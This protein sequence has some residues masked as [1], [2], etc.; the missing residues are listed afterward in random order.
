MNAQI[1]PEIVVNSEAFAV[2]TQMYVRLRRVCGRVIDVMYLVHD[3]SYA[4][5]VAEIALAS[6]DVELQR[7]VAR[8]SNCLDLY[9]EPPMLEVEEIQITALEK[10]EDFETYTQEATAE[11]I[12]QAQVSHHYIGALR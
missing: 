3:P 10:M 2:A 9:P 8:L 7:Q 11:E 1:N 5:Y 12:Y 4:R 6:Q